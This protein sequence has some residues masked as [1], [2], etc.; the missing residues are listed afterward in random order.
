MAVNM[1][2]FV[3]DNNLNWLA[4]AACI[5]GKM[6]AGQA[7]TEL[8]LSKYKKRTLA[9]SLNVDEIVWMLN[10]GM[11]IKTIG[12]VVGANAETV[13]RALEMKGVKF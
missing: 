9:S 13:K 10:K 8:G 6:S 11:K 5:Y 4:L 2:E 3:P 12:R 1:S 7:L